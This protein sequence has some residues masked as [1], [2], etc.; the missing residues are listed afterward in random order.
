V[1]LEGLGMKK[2]TKI[3]SRRKGR[4]GSPYRNLPASVSSPDFHQ[5]NSRRHA[6][7]GDIII[8]SKRPPRP[9]A[10][11][12]IIADGHVETNGKDTDGDDGASDGSRVTT[13]CE[14]CAEIDFPRLLD[15]HVGEPR[16]WVSLSHTLADSE[17]PF[18]TFFQAMIGAEPSDE[19]GKFTPYLR[20]RQAFER[21]GGLGE[22][23]GLG[24]EV[25]VEVTTK[26]KSLPWGYIVKAKKDEHSL[27]GYVTTT[28]VIRGRTVTP[29]LDPSVP[30]TWINFCNENHQD[31][32]CGNEEALVE[33][34]RLIDCETSKVVSGHQL[35]EGYVK[36]VALSYVKGDK[37]TEPL[38]ED[39]ALPKT[40][41]R[42]FQDAISF[43]KSMGYRYLWVDR[44]CFTSLEPSQQKHQIDDVGE[45]FARAAVTFIVASGT[46]TDHGIPGVSEQREDQLS[47][48]TT[49]G[50]FTTS[51]LRCDIEIGRSKWSSRGWTFQEGLLSRRRL[52]FTPSQVYFQCQCLHCHESLSLPLSLA[53]TVK[54]G[55]VFP[56]PGALLQRGQIK[57]QIKAYIPKAFADNSDRL[58]AFKGVLRK[59]SQMKP[60]IDHFVGLPLFHPDDFQSD[61]VVSETDRLAVAL[62]WMPYR[63]MPFQGYVDPYFLDSTFP[64]WTWLAWWL[65]SGQSTLN[66]SFHFNLVD[67]T[68]PLI[69]GV[70]AAPEMEISVGFTDKAVLSWEIDGDAISKKADQIRFLRIETFCFNLKIRKDSESITLVDSCLGQTSKDTIEAWFRSAIDASAGSG[71]SEDND[72]KA[73]AGDY[74]LVGVLISGRDW[75]DDEAESACTVLICRRQ[76]WKADGELVRL[77]ALGITYDGFSRTSERVAV[78]K[79]VGSGS[80]AEKKDVEVQLR[81]L[82]LY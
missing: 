53:S 14:T 22:R 1:H 55:R 66:H 15:W 12:R 45:I 23:H 31:E 3:L 10:G 33:N 17:C 8:T 7:T 39:S 44:Y 21:M 65:K 64:S 34:I 74:D 51:L 6:Q 27:E 30:K 75:T 63:S 58:D 52:V 42:L 2:F 26:N 56:E 41:P 35:A 68:V 38:C 47:L 61:K 25:L 54:V 29:L 59:Y 60:A 5:L 20:I 78:M 81:E 43:T 48:K 79:G 73:P 69:N 13:I 24:R 62:G 32:D 67:E 4:D 46:G 28:P 57:N 72:E 36:Y 19:T 9:G 80:A 49:R 50:L 76:G 16:P 82:D 11:S 70:C 40:L 18:C 77:G 71:S 37:T